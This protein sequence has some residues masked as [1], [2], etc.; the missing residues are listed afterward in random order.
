MLAHELFLMLTLVVIGSTLLRMAH[1]E[2]KG[3]FRSLIKAAEE[4][5]WVVKRQTGHIV[6]VWKNGRKMT[7]S[8]SASDHRAWFNARAVMRRIEKE[9]A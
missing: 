2:K 3:D 4:R 1:R 5:G 7:M 8:A 9:T 6:L